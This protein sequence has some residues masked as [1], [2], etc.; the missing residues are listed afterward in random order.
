MSPE[1]ATFILSRYVLC[2]GLPFA[3]VK[4]GWGYAHLDGITQLED[5]QV[6]LIQLQLGPEVSYYDALTYISKS[7]Q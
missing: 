5:L 1:R 3:F 7:K 6:T 4:P 2:A